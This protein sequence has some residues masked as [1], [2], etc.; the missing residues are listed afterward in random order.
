MRV[1]V[2]LEAPAPGRERFVVSRLAEIMRQYCESKP[3]LYAKDGL[4]VWQENGESGEFDDVRFMTIAI[5]C[6][7]LHYRIVDWEP[8]R[9]E[10]S[11]FIAAL[12]EAVRELG[13]RGFCGRS[14][15]VFLDASS[16]LGSSSSSAPG[17]THL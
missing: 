8:V 12:R 10:K 15:Q 1:Y 14:M 7:F 17:N 4:S 6:G 11:E 16:V 2:R 5:N 13:A 3:H 9:L